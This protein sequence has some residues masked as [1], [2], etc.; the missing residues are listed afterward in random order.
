MNIYDR[1]SEAFKNYK[2]LPDAEKAWKK[3]VRMFAVLL[4]G[5]FLILGSL[6]A[7]PGF[8]ITYRGQWFL[9][10]FVIALSMFAVPVFSFQSRSLMDIQLFH[11]IMFVLYN[12]NASSPSA[13]NSLLSIASLNI[14]MGNAQNARFA[15]ELIDI[16]GLKLKSKPVYEKVKAYVENDNSSSDETYTFE[17]LMPGLYRR[18][19][20]SKFIAIFIVVCDI[21]LIAGLVYTSVFY[22]RISA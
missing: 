7:R 13:A 4:V 6:I 12:K 15:Y 3:N 16:T 9:S 17:R 11:D 8:L 14:I 22:L 1:S 19:K 5:V 10:V 20:C 18:L 2:P 21:L